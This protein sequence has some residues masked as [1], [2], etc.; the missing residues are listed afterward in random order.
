MTTSDINK[1]MAEDL[2]SRNKI[3][4]NIKENYFVEAGAGSGKTKVL[5][6]RM[7]AMVESGIDVKKI[8]AITFTKAAANEFYQRFYNKL[9]ERSKAPTINNYTPQIDELPQPNEESRHNCKKAIKDIDLCFMGTIDSF[10]NMLLNEHP[11]EAGVP[12]S[13][14][15]KSE[16]EFLPIYKHEFIRISRGDYGEEIKQLCKNFISCYN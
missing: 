2:E 1:I 7:V 12:A 11:V 15:V 13:I 16:N 4:H 9:L 5:V 10:C 6:D 14:S 3:I 8:C